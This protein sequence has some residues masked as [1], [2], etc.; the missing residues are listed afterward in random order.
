M[1]VGGGAMLQGANVKGELF[2]ADVRVAGYLAFGG[3]RYIN[4]G[5]W[6]IRA[7]NSR[8]GS[9]LT[10][11]LPENRFAPLGQKTVIVGGCRLDRARIGDRVA[12]SALRLLRFPLRTRRRR[13]RGL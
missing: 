12:W 4:P 11:T 6:A 8:V 3:G 5:N 7:P 13:P 9:N 10:F 2:L 1:I